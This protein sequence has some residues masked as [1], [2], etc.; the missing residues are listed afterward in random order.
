MSCGGWV[1][2]MKRGKATGAHSG[3]WRILWSGASLSGDLP[4]SALKIRYDRLAETTNIGRNRSD[5]PGKCIDNG[6]AGCTGR[7]ARVLRAHLVVAAAGICSGIR[8]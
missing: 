4:D 2:T 6:S 7:P 3:C 1:E 5:A 8:G